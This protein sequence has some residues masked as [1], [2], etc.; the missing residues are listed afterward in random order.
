MKTI[1]RTTQFKRD[2]KR[3][4]KRGQDAALFKEIVQDLVMGKPLDE[5]YRDHAL[6]G[7]YKGTRECHITPDWLLIYES[8]PDEIILIRTGAHTDLFD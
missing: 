5:H 6:S 1:A 2:F 3:A 7:G 4:L 8:T